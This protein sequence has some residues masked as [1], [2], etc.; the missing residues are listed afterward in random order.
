MHDDR[1]TRGDA[2]WFDELGARQ[3]L[4]IGPMKSLGVGGGLRGVWVQAWWG[5]QGEEK[6][7]E[8]C[9]SAGSSHEK[10]LQEPDRDL[11][12]LQKLYSRV[13]SN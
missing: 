7:R 6:S 1:P 4:A 5:W 3:E 12:Q 9:F 11:A 2:S 10:V 8:G 13:V